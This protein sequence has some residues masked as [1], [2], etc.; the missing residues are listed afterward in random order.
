MR[1]LACLAM[2]V[3]VVSWAGCAHVEDDIEGQYEALQAV[4]GGPQLPLCRW[5]EGR[6][7]GQRASIYPVKTDP[8]LVAVD[9]RDQ[10]V[11]VEGSEVVLR[12]G[13]IAVPPI[14]FPRCNICDGTPLPADQFND[15][16]RQ[17][18]IQ[19]NGF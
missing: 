17:L 4:P 6:L 5:I 18:R 7:R 1:N 15:R 13:I 8:R 9:I 19:E 14:M 10:I 16:V 11:C 12:V 3:A 2:L